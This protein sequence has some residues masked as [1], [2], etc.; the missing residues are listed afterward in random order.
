MSDGTKTTPSDDAAIAD[1]GA[2]PDAAADTPEDKAEMALPNQEPIIESAPGEKTPPPEKPKSKA[3]AEKLDP[4]YAKPASKTDAAPPAPRVGAWSAR[5]HLLAGAFLAATLIFGVGVWSSVATIA[6]AVIASGQLRVEGDRKTVQ[7]VDGGKVADILVQEGDTV[8]AG[9]TLIRLESTTIEANVEIIEG[10]LDELLSRRARLEAEMRGDEELVAPPELAERIERRPQAERMF[11]GQ[12]ALF[13]ARIETMARRMD[14]LEKRVLQIRDE[15]KGARG[16]IDALDDQLRLVA[17]ELKDKRGLLAKKLIQRTQVTALERT[18]A[19]LKGE[20]SGLVSEIARLEGRISEIEINMLELGSTRREEAIETLRDLSAR[21][22]ELRERLTV[23]LEQLANVEIKSPQSGK[24]ID[25]KVNTVGG[26]IGAGE[27]IM[28]I[29]PS[30]NEMFL[31]ARI[32]P[33][34]RD[35]IYLDQDAVV[36]FS[37]FNQ[38]TT[39]ELF[40]KVRTIGGDAQV[41]ESTGETYYRIEILVPDE[42]LARLKASID[43]D[44]VPGLPAEVFVQTGERTAA[45]YLLK[46]FLDYLWGVGRDD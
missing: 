26:V 34:E 1:H 39:P 6:G 4:T 16:R 20:R 36:R 11:K 8:L 5:M 23:L 7:H 9:V 27:P 10:Q 38:R 44:L 40:G 19:G 32:S 22:V 13:N 42:E 17:S 18:E 21:V 46:P 12:Q 14:Q 35:R 30:E 24:V 31:E 37:S 25:L 3:E 2:K 41:V 33:F 45:N 15:I 28:D 29:V 43:S